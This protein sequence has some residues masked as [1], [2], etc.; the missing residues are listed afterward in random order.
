MKEIIKKHREWVQFM[1]TKKCTICD[2]SAVESELKQSDTIH[3][4]YCENCVIRDE[5]NE[6]TFKH[7]FGRSFY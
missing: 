4:L 3:G 5:M 1:K 6:H 7:A 2:V